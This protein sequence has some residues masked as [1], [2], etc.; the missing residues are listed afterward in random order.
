MSIESG[1]RGF[2]K[3]PLF[4]EEEKGGV[5]RKRGRE[6]EPLPPA[7]RAKIEVGPMVK[8]IHQLASLSEADFQKAES[9]EDLT[10]T[11]FSKVVIS[12]ELQVTKEGSKDLKHDL[13]IIRSR[14]T[15]HPLLDAATKKP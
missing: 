12:G 13:S 11:L 7:K 8:A 1:V 14:I 15:Q 3:E 9:V 4:P 6:G 5:K 2:A 10:H